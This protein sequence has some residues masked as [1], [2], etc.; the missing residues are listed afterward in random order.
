MASLWYS[1]LRK[2][3]AEG[4]Y[5]RAPIENVYGITFFISSIKYNSEIKYS[6][7][8]AKKLDFNFKRKI[9]WYKRNR[10]FNFIYF[11]SRR[12][13]EDLL[14]RLILYKI[15]NLLPSDIDVHTWKS[16]CFIWFPWQ[17]RRGWP[18]ILCT[19]KYFFFIEYHDY[20]SFIEKQK[21]LY[22]QICFLPINV[23]INKLSSFLP[24]HIFII[25]VPAAFNHNHNTEIFKFSSH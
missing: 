4:T 12:H 21:Q 22:P 15:S 13:V 6:R 14:Y 3:T 10:W 19:S 17:I 2:I 7:S 23:K 16:P 8:T 18:R 24:S 1:G 11:G 5:L 25:H 20:L 9:G